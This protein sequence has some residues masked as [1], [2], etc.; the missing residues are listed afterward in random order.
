MKPKKTTGR[1]H[2]AIDKASTRANRIDLLKRHLRP[3]KHPEDK[4]AAARLD[5]L[6]RAK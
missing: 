2:R 6:R 5:E 1:T 4:Q 3:G